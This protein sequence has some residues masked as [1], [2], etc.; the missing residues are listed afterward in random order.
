MPD[1]TNLNIGNNNEIYSGLTGHFNQVPGHQIHVLECKFHGNMIKHI[2]IKHATPD[3][4]P[5]KSV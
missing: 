5:P 4:M 2:E 1:T 3:R